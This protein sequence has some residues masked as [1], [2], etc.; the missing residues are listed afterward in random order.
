MPTF[1]KG[2]RVRAKATLFDEGTA[3]RNGLL[4][5]QKWAADGHGEWCY[6][7]VSWIYCRRGR[8]VQRYRVKYDEGTTQEALE[9]HLELVV[10]EE[11]SDSES[12][13]GNEM[14]GS[15]DYDS[16]SSTLD[17][18]RVRDVIDGVVIAAEPDNRAEGETVTSESEGE[19]GE[20]ELGD[21]RNAL[22][23][24]SVGD[25]VTVHGVTWEMIEGLQED[26]RTEPEVETRFTRLHFNFITSD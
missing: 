15:Q 26:Q 19:M 8:Q 5:S 24:M 23:P 6:G 10:G 11:D 4:F 21:L 17:G 13:E 1:A 7:S 16:E 3:D 2:D 9:E 20:G 25:R 12:S 22:E 14:G 18:P